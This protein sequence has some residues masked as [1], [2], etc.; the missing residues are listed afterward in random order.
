MEQRFFR[1]SLCR[2]AT[3][4]IIGAGRSG[5]ASAKLLLG[6]G[7]K[8]H[9]YDDQTS[10]NLRYFDAKAMVH[11]DRLTT[12]FATG[13]SGPLE[14]FSAVILSPGVRLDHQLVEQAKAA[15]LPILSEIDLASLFLPSHKMIGITGTNGKSTTTVMVESI[16]RAAG[17]RAWACGN[18]GNPL[19]DLVSDTYEDNAPYFVVELSSFQLETTVLTQLDRAIIVNITPDHLDRYLSFEA[20]AHAKY[21]IARLLKERSM[22]FVNASLRDIAPFIL[23]PPNYFSAE[24]FGTGSY[25]YLRNTGILGLHN[26]ENAMAAVKVAESLGIAPDVIVA[27]LKTYKPLPHRCEKVDVKKGVTYI[28]DSKGTTVVAVK[29]A[30][31]MFN[32]PTHLL[33]GGLAK[34]E[35]FGELGLNQYP[36]IVGYYVFGHAANKILHAL[37]SPIGFYCENLKD[38]VHLAQKRAKSGDIVLLS[39]GCASFDQFN[40]YQHR[41]ETFRA[42]IKEL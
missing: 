7:L 8:V 19:C 31:S 33:L 37:M 2:G 36:H 41:G 25:S 14:R 5:I 10:E 18:L 15:R 38:A 28:N 27:G 13:L 6:R 42:L 11:H 22:L 39:P 30:L 20:Y 9:L 40:D 24:E 12:H 16:L 4:L 29:K 17:Q 32:A 23:P 3:V 1:P 26:Q 21:Q 34:G 35:D